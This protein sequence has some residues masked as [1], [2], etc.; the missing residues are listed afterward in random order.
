MQ[1][2]F[3]EIVD[4]AIRRLKGGETALFTFAGEESDFVRFNH[5]RVRQA[6]CVTQRNLGIDL[7]RGRRHAEA[8]LALSGR[9]DEDRDRLLLALAELRPRLD[10]LP[11]DPHLMYATEARSTE[12]VG[13]NH[14]APAAE[15]VNAALAACAGHDAVG[16]FAQGPI[17]RGFANSFGQR[18][19]FSTHT[20]N[21]EWCLYLR[22]DKA[23]KSEYSG[24][25]WDPDVL[26]ERMSAATHQLGL[27]DREPKTIAPGKYRAYLAPKALE[28][29]A[30]IL[31]WS[32]FGLKDHRAKISSLIRM[33]ESGATF[34]PC[35]TIRENTREG[36]APNFDERGYVKPDQVVLVEGGRFHDYLVSP[37][38]AKE[39]DLPTN[40]AS[41]Q[42]AST[43]FDLAAGEIEEADIL[44]RLDTGLYIN[45]LWYLNYSD[46]PACRVTGMTRF[47]T[48]WVERGA[49]VAP[50]QV[51]RF[52]ESMY[53]LLG[54]HLLGLTRNRSM[55]LS[56]ETYGGRQVSSARL[57]GALVEDFSLTL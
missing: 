5:A 48:F 18:N 42:E 17:H 52:D 19:W 10:S 34:H 47:A 21:L 14:L 4:F 28:E 40:G 3:F 41:A 54:S 39:Y 37:R 53:R 44:A 36:V 20:F 30:G 9:P 51:M 6:G 56:S 1:A 45:N 7:I 57:P 23:V 31:N 22:D 16:I 49:L 29:I 2:D 50:L 46:R 55:I 12:R 24:F 15:A 26:R 32:G 13:E 33:T 43:S 8:R 35:V 25:D 27:L 11:E 38:S